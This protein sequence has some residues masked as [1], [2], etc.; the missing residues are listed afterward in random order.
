MKKKKT[1]QFDQLKGESQTQ[2]FSQHKAAFTS[3][4]KKTDGGESRE[5]LVRDLR[6]KGYRWADN[7]NVR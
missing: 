4:L 7:K 3:E 6:N 5:V 2:K 1:P